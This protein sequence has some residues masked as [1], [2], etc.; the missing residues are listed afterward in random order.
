MKSVFYFLILTCFISLQ[1]N[2]AE[3]QVK[4]PKLPLS[5]TFSKTFGGSAE[6]DAFS[7]CEYDTSQSEVLMIGYDYSS[8]GDIAKNNGDADWIIMNFTR[9]DSPRLQWENTFGGLKYDKGR[10]ITYSYNRKSYIGFGT[11]HSNGGDVD[12]SQLNGITNRDQWWVVKFNSKGKILTQKLIVG[13]GLNGGRSIIPTADN[14][15]ICMGWSTSNDN[16]FIGNY[17]HNSVNDKTEDGYLFKLDSN[18]NVQWSNHY[19]GTGRDAPIRMI[20]AGGYYYFSGFSTSNDFDFSGQNHRNGSNNSYDGCVLKVDSMGHLVWSKLY[21][22]TNTDY[23]YD[24]QAD[25]DGNILVG[26]YTYSNNGDV[27]VNHGNADGWFFK[28]SSVDGHLMWQKSFGGTKYDLIKRIVPMYDHGYVLMLSSSSSDDDAAKTGHHGQSKD[29][30]LVRV[31]SNL[32]IMYSHSYG[33]NGTEDPID[34]LLFPNEGYLIVANTDSKDGDLTGI[35]DTTWGKDIWVLFVKDIN[36]V[37]RANTLKKKK[38]VAVIPVP[39]SF[40]V[41]PTITTGT[42]AV[43][44]SSSANESYKILVMNMEGKVVYTQSFA[45]G[46]YFTNSTIDLSDKPKGLYLVEQVYANGNK[47]TQKIVLQ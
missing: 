28:V 27:T 40:S 26:G 34:I 44:S 4:K 8:D 20:Q 43:Q 23:P 5:I 46:N 22:G 25:Y 17:D 42:I 14:G 13:L 15:C 39:S 38:T 37:N 9:T 29:I 19:G 41:N 10:N 2:K 31:D 30:W 1:Q 16:A 6:D 36:L 33:G 45:E 3:A 21:G 32:N 24:V 7:F 18:L 12:K 11:S 35:K 47:E